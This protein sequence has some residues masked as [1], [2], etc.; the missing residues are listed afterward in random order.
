[1]VNRLSTGTTDDRMDERESEREAM[2]IDDLSEIY[3]SCAH[4]LERDVFVGTCACLH[5]HL[6]SLSLQL[7]NSFLL[8]SASSKITE[9]LIVYAS[10]GNLVR[11]TLPM[12]VFLYCQALG[13]ES[14]SSG[15]LAICRVS[16]NEIWSV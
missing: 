6:F 16:Y 5:F 12:V 8:Q 11:G 10:S 1:M 15:W 3:E 7:H 9:Y 13:N 2:M 4:R 14:S